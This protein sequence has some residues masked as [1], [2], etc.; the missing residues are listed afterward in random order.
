MR[1]QF[2]VLNPI[3]LCGERIE[4]GQVIEIEPEMAANAPGYFE[5]ISPAPVAQPEPEAPAAPEVA[6]APVAPEEA[7]KEPTE[8]VAP[9]EAEEIA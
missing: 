8:I 7:A 1:Q 2:K 6:E 4:R 9:P 3:S 5:A